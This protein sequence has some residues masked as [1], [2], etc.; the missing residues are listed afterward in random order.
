MSVNVHH[1]SGGNGLIVSLHESET[2]IQHDPKAKGDD[3]PAP[4]LAEM[5]GV[6]SMTNHSSPPHST[7]NIKPDDI[8]RLGHKGLS[9]SKP[10][11]SFNNNAAPKQHSVRSNY[12]NKS[13]KSYG[14]RKKSSKR[15]H[16]PPPTEL[17]RIGIAKRI[18]TNTIFREIRQNYYEKADIMLNHYHYEIFPS[19]FYNDKAWNLLGDKEYWQIIDDIK[20]IL[21]KAVVKR[22]KLR[23]LYLKNPYL[24]YMYK[25][26][27]ILDCIYYSVN[28]N[29]GVHN[30]DTL[31]PSSLLC[32]FLTL[33]VYPYLIVGALY[34]LLYVP[35]YFISM[36]AD[37]FTC[38]CLK[39][40]F[41]EAE[42]TWVQKNIFD[43]H[44][45]LCTSYIDEEVFSDMTALTKHVQDKYGQ[46]TEFFSGIEKVEGSG[47]EES[48]EL[49]EFLICFPSGGEAW[50]NATG[51]PP[52]PKNEDM[53]TD[54]NKARRGSF[55]SMSS[56]YSGAATDSV[57][58]RKSST[59]IYGIV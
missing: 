6:T 49:D 46:V 52:S 39:S 55:F 13:Q 30:I 53:E 24:P 59:S 10:N 2:T 12:A 40:R 51:G 31:S 43:M 11:S 28:E 38:Q 33:G 36:L 50:I 47:D 18:D 4:R 1:H 48:Y 27:G 54:T 56:F 5:Y 14:A 20:I 3:Q 58:T 34:T 57:L 35:V 42:M 15:L 37:A 8:T 26:P 23:S 17:A 44:P 25:W 29:T 16:L 21:A 19:P 9:N 7:H 45:E 22:R 32:I 41:T